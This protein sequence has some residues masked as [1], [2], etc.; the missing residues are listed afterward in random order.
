MYGT[1]PGST[2]PDG[3][4]KQER[5]DAAERDHLGEEEQGRGEAALACLITPTIDGP[6]RPPRLP[7]ELTSAIPAAAPGPVRIVVG[8]DQNVLIAA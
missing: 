6:T 7:T 2:R 4:A 5:D 3:V 1:K 8:S